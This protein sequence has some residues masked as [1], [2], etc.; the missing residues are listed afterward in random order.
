MKRDRPIL[1]VLG[2]PPYNGYAG[3][4]QTGK[5]IVCYI[6]NYSWLDGLSTGPG[7]ERP[8]R[9]LLPHGRAP[10]RAMDAF[11]RPVGVAEVAFFLDRHC[12]AASRSSSRAGYITDFGGFGAGPPY[13]R[14]PEARSWRRTS[15]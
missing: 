4:S 8:L 9:P 1:V 5:G 7:P 10:N 15:G 11:R 2:N 12:S 14:A 13:L 6:S 3:V